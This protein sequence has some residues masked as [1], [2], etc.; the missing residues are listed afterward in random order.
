MP[1][2][3]F[4][5]QT[6][7]FTIHYLPEPKALDFGALL[8]IVLRRLL[9]TS[10]G[11]PTLRGYLLTL[12][13]SLRQGIGEDSSSFRTCTTEGLP[14]LLG[15]SVGETYGMEPTDQWFNSIQD[16]FLVTSTGTSLS[17]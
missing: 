7:A 9:L 11:W 15:T 17:I 8:N 3:S 2:N 1:S 6:D 12:S 14:F 5:F 4:L 13:S 10:R 16:G